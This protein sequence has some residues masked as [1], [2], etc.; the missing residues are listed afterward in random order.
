MRFEM[1]FYKTKNTLIG[2][3]AFF[4][5]SA[6]NSIA[7]R[8]KLVEGLKL[9]EVPLKITETLSGKLLRTKLPTFFSQARTVIGLILP[10]FS[11]RFSSVVFPFYEKFGQ[12]NL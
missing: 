3:F 8:Q 12:L 5:L 10:Y 4:M 11:F 1:V 6:C 9:S 2:L 7:L